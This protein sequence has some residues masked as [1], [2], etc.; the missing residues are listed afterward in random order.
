MQANNCNCLNCFFFHTQRKSQSHMVQT[1]HIW[2]LIKTLS[3]W[4]CHLQ[5][6]WVNKKM[7]QHCYKIWHKKLLLFE[8][9]LKEFR[10][11]NSK[12][13]KTLLLIICILLL[14]Y[15]SLD[16]L[17]FLAMQ[18]LQLDWNGNITTLSCFDY[19]LFWQKH[20]VFCSMEERYVR[21]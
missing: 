9:I 15:Y 6:K 20:I 18:F 12:F 1:D 2:K 17:K 10:S 7:E 19:M 14:P 5:L 16:I 8:N 11:W 13:L 21:K 3:K 4:A